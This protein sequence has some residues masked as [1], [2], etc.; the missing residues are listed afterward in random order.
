MGA[1]RDQLALQ[2]GEH[3]EHGSAL[4]NGSVHA[5]LDDVDLDATLAQLG[6]AGHRVRQRVATA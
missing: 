4:G 1:G 6:S 3:A 2:A 5:L